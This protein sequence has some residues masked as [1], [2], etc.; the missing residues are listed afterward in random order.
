MI[1]KDEK[2]LLKTIVRLHNDFSKLEQTHPA[3]ITEWI[4][5]IHILQN[6]IAFRITRRDYPETFITIKKQPKP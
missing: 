2:R 6:V 1:T 3:D 4:N 5:G